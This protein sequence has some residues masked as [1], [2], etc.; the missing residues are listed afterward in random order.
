MERFAEPVTTLRPLAIACRPGTLLASIQ[1]QLSRS[2]DA[3]PVLCTRT[4]RTDRLRR[5]ILAHRCRRAKRHR[6]RPPEQR[7]RLPDRAGAQSLRA[8]RRHGRRGAWRSGQRSGCGDRRLAIAR[9]RKTIAPRRSLSSP[10]QTFPSSTNRLASAV[11]LANRKIF[12]SA[13]SQ[14]RAH[15]AW[16]RRSS[17]RGS[18]ASG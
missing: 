15:A 16:A 18:A 3:L 2:G 11:T 4:C 8:F 9:R 1:A 13:S 5:F 6:S 17:R 10:G 12:D 7:R 14:H